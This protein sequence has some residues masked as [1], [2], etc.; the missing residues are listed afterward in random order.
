ME[1]CKC[2]GAKIKLPTKIQRVETYLNE[3]ITEG[4]TDKV[5]VKT[6]SSGTGIKQDYVRNILCNQPHTRE[7]LNQLNY[8]TAKNKFNEQWKDVKATIQL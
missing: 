4:V 5:T 8:F 6:I 2:C 7:I 3:F 1:V